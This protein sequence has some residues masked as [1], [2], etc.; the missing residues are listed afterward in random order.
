MLTGASGCNPGAPQVAMPACAQLEPLIGSVHSWCRWV[1]TGTSKVSFKD[2]AEVVPSK[3]V[4][5]CEHRALPRLMSPPQVPL[6]SIRNRK[7]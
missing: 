4:G 1:M 3:T 6:Q 7:A 2:R 5:G